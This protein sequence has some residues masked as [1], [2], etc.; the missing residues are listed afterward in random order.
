MRI[1]W[2]N[3]WD[4]YT[5]TAN[6]EASGYPAI[7]IQDISYKKTTR[8]TGDTSEWWKIGDGVNKIK[9]SDIAIAG[10]NF[11]SGATITLQGNDTD[12]WTSPAKEEVLT[13]NADIITKFFTA[14]EYYYWRL[15]VA[16]A[17]NPDTYI[18]IGRISSDEY[19]QMPGIEPGLVYPRKTTSTKDI[20]VTG[21][22]YGDKGIIARMPGF[23]FP[24][25]EDSERIQIDAMFDEV[26]NIKPIFLIVY[27]NSLD[28][29]PAL[30]CTI[31][32]DEL[33]W[34]KS[35]D[36]LAWSIQIKFLEAF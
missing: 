17:S 1:I 16:D 4:K 36:G 34:Q 21:Q 8:S 18:E 29:I 14:V 24:I 33:P 31:D 28:V 22:V 20:T 7:N 11:T 32:Q 13:Y 6:S 30:Y 9:I 15:L 26:H 5:I 19:L 3:A 25:I 27:E 2:D 10:H 23:A 12:V 35:K